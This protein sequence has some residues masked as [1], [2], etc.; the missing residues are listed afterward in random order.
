MIRNY[1]KILNQALSP[2]LASDFK[3]LEVR[4]NA[5]WIIQQVSISGDTLKEL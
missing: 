1:K 5:L 3:T 4:Y 2:R